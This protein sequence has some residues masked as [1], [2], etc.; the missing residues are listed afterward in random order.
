MISSQ[1]YFLVNSPRDWFKDFNDNSLKPYF[2]PQVYW[3]GAQMLFGSRFNPPWRLISQTMRSIFL[4]WYWQNLAYK[5]GA[6]F[7]SL[8]IF[9]TLSSDLSIN[10]LHLIFVCK[11]RISWFWSFFCL[12]TMMLTHHKSRV[13]VDRLKTCSRN[14]RSKFWTKW[15][16][17][18]LILHVSLCIL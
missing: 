10:S 18:L 6:M 2:E 8:P 5:S 16:P 15:F 9:Q 1:T 7:S 12:W 17:H 4:T 11:N 3:T 13:I 14:S